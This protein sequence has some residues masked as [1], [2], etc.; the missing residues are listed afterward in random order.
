MKA[1]T[2]SP[3]VLAVAA[4]PDDIEFLMSG[5]MLRLREAGW[6][7]HYLNLANGCCGTAT[8]PAQAIA[9]RRRGEAIE[10]ARAIGATFHESMVNDLEIFYDYDL[11]ARVIA[12]VREARP[13][14]LLVHSPDDYM[15]DHT[16]S[17]RV[18][19]TAAFCR[20]MINY[21]SIPERSP[22]ADEVTIYHA[23]PAGMRGPL[24]QRVTAGQYVDV[25]PTMAT[26]RA[27][28]AC[29]RS[30]KEWLDVSQ[31]MDSYLDIMV[32]RCREA[33]RLSGRFEYAEGWRRH[34]HLGFSATDSDPLGDAL[35]DACWT[36]PQYE[37]A[38]G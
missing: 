36:D 1:S 10:A 19:V 6:R 7:L 2:N 34:N 23:M 20:G 30:Q 3:A 22:V 24:R 5:T 14:I 28:L 12:V 31:G 16:I 26:K 11:I 38:L 17:Q 21:V 25:S 4:H 29:H 32:E 37:A 33:G 27:M 18:A 9:A 13:R 15:E 8:E 35:G